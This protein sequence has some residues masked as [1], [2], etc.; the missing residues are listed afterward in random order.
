MSVFSPFS[1]G[2]NEALPVWFKPFLELLVIGDK[3][4]AGGQGAMPIACFTD[5]R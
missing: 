3:E 4:L 5:K 2:L 1:Q